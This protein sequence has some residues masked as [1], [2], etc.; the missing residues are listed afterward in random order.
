M[1]RVTM[2]EIADN[3]HLSKS[4]VSR[5][6]SNKYGVNEKT[7]ALILH[8]ASRL[9]YQGGGASHSSKTPGKVITVYMQRYTLT[10]DVNFGSR[11]VSGIE[12]AISK[13]Y[14]Q[15]NLVLVD[16]CAVLDLADR[17]R[18]SFG[19]IVCSGIEGLLLEQLQKLGIPI[20]MIDPIS[21]GYQINCIFA[22]N[23]AGTYD[24]TSYL[25]RHGHR[26]LLFLGDSSYSYAFLQRFHGFNDCVRDHASLGV[27][28]SAITGK[29]GLPRTDMA[30]G[31]NR[32]ALIQLLDRGYD[33]TAIVCAN[34]PTALCT[35][36]ILKARG[37]R[38]PE[39]ISIVGFDNVVDTANTEPPLT[40][41][42][43][44]KHQLG[45]SAVSMLADNNL[46]QNSPYCI[47]LLGVTI[48]E[49]QSVRTIEAH[50]TKKSG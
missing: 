7:K 29:S 31:F 34:D 24:I 11:I 26:R 4:L 46:I 8:E 35:Y 5:A 38:I 50:E 14:L 42:N 23:Y 48:V 41:L 17:A 49:R 30:S 47:Q 2:Q 15:M 39:D 16:D 3:L 25:I 28:G 13:R 18:N 27:Q 36:D 10:G 45:E 43:I 1:K 6:L 20:V 37:L 19:I 32:N 22:D 33:A 12:R 40:T 21:I 44:S 9:H